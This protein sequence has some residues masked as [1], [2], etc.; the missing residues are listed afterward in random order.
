MGVAT[1]EVCPRVLVVDDH[2]AMAE[3][4]ADALRD[5]GYDAVA[6]P[7]G[8]EARR[9]LEREPFDALVTDLR[10]PDVDGLALLALSRELSPARPVI[11]M[12]SWSTTDGALAAIRQGAYHCLR[13]PFRTD[14]LVS[15]LAR[16]LAEARSKRGT[17]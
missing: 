13:K 17:E 7:S 16:A 8:G 6:V 4:V 5:S 10:M 15:F 2:F 9:R 12:T 3:T 14:E 1:G 11:V